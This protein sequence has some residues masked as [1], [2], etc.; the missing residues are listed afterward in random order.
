MQE[1]SRRTLRVCMEPDGNDILA[2]A[3]ERLP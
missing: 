2:R 1:I 3:G